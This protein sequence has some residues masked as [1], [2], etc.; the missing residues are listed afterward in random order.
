MTD[1]PVEVDL[2]P[3]IHVY[4]A[5]GGVIGPPGPEGP[6]GPQG[7]IGPAG[8]PGADGAPGTDGQD[9]AQGP[10]GPPGP[11]GADSTVP[12]PQGP[13]GADSTVPGPQGPKGDQGV[14]GPAGAPGD[15]D[16]LIDGIQMYSRRFV[17]A[18]WNPVNNRMYLTYFTSDRTMTAGSLVFYSGNTA[19]AA[20]P[21]LIRFGLYRVEA[22]GDLTLIGSTPNDTTLFSTTAT[23]W[24]K[25]MSAP[26]GVTAGQRYAMAMLFISAAAAPLV[27]GNV[28]FGGTGFPANAGVNA[29]PRLVAQ[30]N[31]QSDLPS[32]IPQASIGFASQCTYGEVFP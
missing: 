4:E 31:G 16:S 1:P 27:Y 2:P 14:P 5:E 8:P 30:M 21:T 7:P 17:N 9:G 11:A 3:I 10:Q 32:S 28:P 29:N 26:V 24:S 15:P 22:N 13:A 18:T 6:A 20:T 19:A 23:R 25:A 12:G